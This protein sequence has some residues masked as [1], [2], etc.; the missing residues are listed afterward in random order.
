MKGLKAVDGM[1]YMESIFT[2]GEQRESHFGVLNVLK[3][4][5]VDYFSF[6]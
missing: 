2:F 3:E 5:I 1:G 4:C 6:E